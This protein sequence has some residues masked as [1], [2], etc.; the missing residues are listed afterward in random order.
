MKKQ[1][2]ERLSETDVADIK[3]CF[4]TGRKDH[5]ETNWVIEAPPQVREKLL[6]SKVFIS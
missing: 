4:R 2:Q 3:F 1:N 5:Q 6:R